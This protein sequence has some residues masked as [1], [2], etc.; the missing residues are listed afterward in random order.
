METGQFL[1]EAVAT[2]GAGGTAIGVEVG[3]VSHSLQ[4]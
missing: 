1:E 4:F 3:G 2:V